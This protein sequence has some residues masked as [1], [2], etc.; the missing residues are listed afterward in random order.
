MKILLTN[1][2][3]LTP[4]ISSL[5]TAFDEHDIDFAMITESWLQESRILAQ[6]IVDLEH[7]TGLKI[8]YKNRPARAAG[9]RA[10]GG[11]V[12]IIYKKASCKFKE[13]KVVGNRFEMVVATGKSRKMARHLAI[14]CIY[15]QP[16]LLVEDLRKLR[17]IISDELLAIK[18]KWPD[19]LVFVGGDM[20]KKNIEEAFDCYGDIARCNYGPTRGDACL[21]ILYTNAKQAR[22][23]TSTPLES[24]AGQA[25]DHACIVFEILEPRK[26]NFEWVTVKRRKHSDTAVAKYAA[27]LRGTDWEKVMPQ[28]VD[29]P[30]ALVEAFESYTTALTEEL[31]PWKTSRRRSNEPPGNTE[32][33]RK[34]SRQKKR[35]YKEEG[36]SR[37]WHRL[38][39]EFD[40]K[41]EDRRLEFVERARKKGPNSKEYLGTIKSLISGESCSGWDVADLFPDMDP[42]Q[43]GDQVTEFFTAITDEF[44]PLQETRT[45]PAHRRPIT[46]EEVRNKLRIAKK[47]SSAVKGDL[48]PR[49]MKR[50][51]GEVVRPVT[52]IFNA[53]FRSGKWPSMWKTETTVIIPKKSSP[54]DLTE[55]RNISC[56]PFLSKVLESVLLEDLRK[57]I[58]TDPSQ[59]GGIKGSSVDHLLAD[60]MDNILRPLDSGNPVVLLAVDFEKAFN[61]LDHKEC[62]K[63]LRR[64]GAEEHLIALVRSFLT[65]RKM[66]AKV[67]GTLS[68]EKLLRGGSPQGSILGCY[69]Y[70][71]T[72]QRIDGSLPRTR[73]RRPPIGLTPARSASGEESEGLPNTVEGEGFN[74]LDLELWPHGDSPGSDGDGLGVQHPPQPSQRNAEESEEVTAGAG[75]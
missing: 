59:Y 68:E 60:L 26:R 9:A 29:D 66:R 71:S 18:A 62:L 45:I 73:N 11:G 61:R 46:E 23:E 25:S 69:L 33:L 38:Q 27:R 56:T 40:T 58:P 3:S 16:R 74:L 57:S 6:D 54:S 49:V 42:G 21:D 51:Y 39:S 37:T 20:N 30:D 34:L 12:S 48:L 24:N 17:E 1:A 10:V 4:K 14:F 50:H 31:F 67:A 53:V 7:G 32:G 55:C 13:R 72:T 75:T 36:K 64:L 8:I 15:L 35:V 41:L 65:N 47:P 63:Q 28:D 43:V 2:R 52:Q 22:Y 19:P 44:E 5:I 70:C